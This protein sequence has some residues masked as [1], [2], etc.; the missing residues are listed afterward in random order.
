MQRERAMTIQDLFIANL[1]DYRKLQNLSQLKLAEL[2]DSSQSY[3]AE[4][5][6]AK[7]FPSPEMI[8][9][10]AKALGIESWC[11]FKNESPT[12]EKQLTPSQK[13]EILE[14]LHRAAA[15]IITQY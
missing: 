5:E 9:R 12:P 4:I 1:K 15:K 13:Q 6:V 8:E 14:K 10:I 11:L 2:C 7:K 3:I